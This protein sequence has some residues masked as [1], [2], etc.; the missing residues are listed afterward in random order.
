M[1]SSYF[2]TDKRPTN[3]TELLQVLRDTVDALDETIAREKR[4]GVA[5]IGD[6]SNGHDV[7]DVADRLTELLTVRSILASNATGLA[8]MG[9]RLNSEDAYG[10]GKNAIDMAMVMWTSDLIAHSRNLDRRD[11]LETF[12]KVK[13]YGELVNLVKPGMY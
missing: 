6:A 8:K 4:G 9:D 11:R 10:T 3:G 7:S 12:A 13:C 2:N 1:F 5:R